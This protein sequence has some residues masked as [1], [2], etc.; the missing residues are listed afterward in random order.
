MFADIALPPCA[1]RF[2]HR[3]RFVHFF[4]GLRCKAGLR[5]PLP[6]RIESRLCEGYGHDAAFLYRMHKTAA[7]P[8]AQCFR[9]FTIE[10]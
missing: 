10:E 6:Q 7:V 8:F 5:D 3:F 4:M 9:S 1:G 2:P